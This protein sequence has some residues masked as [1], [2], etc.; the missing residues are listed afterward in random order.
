MVNFPSSVFV[1][2]QK[3]HCASVSTSLNVIFATSLMLIIEIDDSQYRVKSQ[4]TIFIAVI[5]VETEISIALGQNDFLEE[6]AKEP[7][8]ANLI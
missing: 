4:I 5:I 8:M 7:A 6:F 3:L 2:L 1:T